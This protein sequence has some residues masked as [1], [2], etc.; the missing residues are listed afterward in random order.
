MIKTLEKR[1][2]PVGQLTLLASARSVGRKLK[3][4]GED[5]TVYDASRVIGETRG[6]I[7]AESAV[8]QINADCRV[9]YELPA[10]G[11]AAAVTVPAPIPIPAPTKAAP[12]SKKA[13]PPGK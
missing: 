6:N 5:I 12:S 1:N 7:L 3:F 13:P 4:R 2:F 9:N 11:S 8:A 10:T